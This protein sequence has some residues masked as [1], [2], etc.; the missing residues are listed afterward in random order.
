MRHSSSQRQ[1]LKSLRMLSSWAILAC[2]CLS[3]KRTGERVAKRR[4]DGIRQWAAL[5]AAQR[6]S[7]ILEEQAAIYRAFPELRGA[8]GKG[9][10]GGITLAP[11]IGAAS[12]AA[13]GD[14]ESEQT[15]RRRRR[16]H[17]SPEARKRISDAQK[18]RW[19]KH[20]ATAATTQATRKKR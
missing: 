8:R 5:G 13:S 17:L 10:R 9:R 3:D 2:Q 11:E 16:R 14:A 4:Q 12:D 20:R 15:P 1:V 18:A 6:L 7:Q 19:A